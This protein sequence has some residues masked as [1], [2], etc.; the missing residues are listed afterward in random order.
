MCVVCNRTPCHPRCPNACDVVVD[1]CTQCFCDI[2][3][4]DTFYKDDNGN[5]YCSMDCALEY[6]GI[7]ETHYEG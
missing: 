2:K 6:Y 5:L 4:S 1:G 7:T 3:A